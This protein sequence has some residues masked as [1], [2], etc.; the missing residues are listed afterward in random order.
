MMHLINRKI[1]FM[2]LLCKTIGPCLALEAVICL[3]ICLYDITNPTISKC[4]VF[5]AWLK[6]LYVTFLLKS[7]LF[8]KVDILSCETCRMF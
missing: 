3:W 7:I 4:A 8:L 5:G 1:T 2:V 6:V